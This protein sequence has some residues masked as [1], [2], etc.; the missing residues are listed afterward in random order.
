VSRVLVIDAN[1]ADRR[2]TETSLSA[3]HSVHSARDRQHAQQLLESSAWDVVVLDPEGFASEGGTIMR[4]VRDLESPPEVVI[5]LREARLQSVIET[6]R[7]GAFEFVPKPIDE[8]ALHKALAN[9]MQLKL[10]N[11]DK[12]RID[13]SRR[14]ERQRLAALVEERSAQ[15]RRVF[16]NVPGLLYRMAVSSDGKRNFTFVSVNC[17]ELLELPEE[18]LIGDAQR[19]DA[20]VHPDD[21]ARFRR[22]R[23]LAESASRR[24]RFE[25]RFV[26]R[27]GRTR[28]LQVVARPTTQDTDC[29]WDGII[30][31][32]TERAELESQLLLADRL[33][34]V[35]N[36]A[37]AVAHEVNNPLAYVQS[38]LNELERE[39]STTP[40]AVEAKQLLAEAIEGVS[41]IE[42]T[43]KDLRVFARSS[44]ESQ[45]PVRLTHVLD[46]S[47]RMANNEI[48]HRAQL[49]TS[50]ES[51]ASVVADESNLGQLFLNLLISM[52]QTIPDGGAHAYKIRVRVWDCAEGHVGVELSDNGPG[53]PEDVVERAFDPIETQPLRSG[54]GL[55]IC[56]RIV[57]SLGGGI[58]AT[59][60]QQGT[61]FRITLPTGLT[62]P[63]VVPFPHRKKQRPRA[64][65][66]LVVDD[67]ELVVN[68]L[69]RA[70]EG[71]E[72][73]SAR[74]GR[75]AIALLRTR[76]P[77][78]LVLCDVMMP[79]LTGRDVYEA[80]REVGS[81]QNI[82]FVTGGAFTRSARAFL[83]SVPN[84]Q[85]QKPFSHDSVRSL[86]GDF[87]A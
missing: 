22:E 38:N 28:W 47:I 65:R 1:E 9:A 53:L 76:G 33:A 41:R 45:R 6:L 10:L 14:M 69:C 34:S 16:D 67:E 18:V 80:A 25:G 31:D 13:R 4:R 61:R 58:S 23:D 7:A 71:H 35:G 48:R 52:A 78:D 11:D 46:S 66:V 20:L 21:A 87:D 2:W 62:T 15:M 19:F 24:F 49:E 82:V 60:L 75:E 26:L 43:V 86:L 30:T 40:V 5:T 72:L 8:V 39:L 84:R 73:V 50:Y 56:H 37:A 51:A 63:N 3:E 68:A 29:I 54:L 64:A 36:M 85:I 70:M 74:S 81:E 12:R 44:T 83:E 59:R 32:V 55:Y 27:S 57:Q 79:D 42:N 77:F 17:R